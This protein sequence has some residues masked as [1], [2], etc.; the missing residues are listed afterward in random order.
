MH[1]PRLWRPQLPDRGTAVVSV[2]M[3]LRATKAH[4]N[5]RC[6]LRD[7]DPRT[8]GVFLVSMRATKAQLNDHRELHCKCVQQRHKCSV[9][10]MLLLARPR[11]PDRGGLLVSM[12]ATKAQLN[13]HRELH[14][15]CVQQR[16]KCTVA[17]RKRHHT[18]TARPR[19]VSRSEGGVM[20]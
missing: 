2:S 11:P 18:A 6:C 4:L 19:Y 10:R 8:A 13:E 17:K 16:H 20:P 7:L 14:C 12:R 5:D 9:E 3:P 15:K 1:Y